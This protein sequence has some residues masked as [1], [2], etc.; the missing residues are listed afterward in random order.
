MGSVRRK[1]CTG[2]VT[3]PVGS[4]KDVELKFMHKIVIKFDQTPSKCIHVSSNT[5]EKKRDTDVPISGINVKRSI[6]VTFPVTSGGKFFLC[7]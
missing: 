3:I 1:V 4:K 6:T 7:N 2:K 5:M